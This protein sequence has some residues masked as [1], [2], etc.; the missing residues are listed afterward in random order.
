MRI[1]LDHDKMKAGLLIAVAVVCSLALLMMFATVALADNPHHNDTVTNVYNTYDT[2]VTNVTE[3]QRITD[4]VNTTNI[5]NYTQDEC[6]GV[7][8][9]SAIGNNHMSLAT[10]KPQ[11]SFG[12][13]NCRDEFAGSIMFGVK[14]GKNALINGSYAKDE[15]VNAI[16]LGLTIILK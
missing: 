9:S 3:E 2:Y 7:A 5:S 14:A 12:V 10:N 8:I 15:N 13:G 4:L 6:N 16:G 1:Q 11:L